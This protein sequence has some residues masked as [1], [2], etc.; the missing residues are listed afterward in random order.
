MK[1]PI[2]LAALL[3]ASVFA[4]ANAFVLARLP[5][6]LVDSNAVQ[7]QATSALTAANAFLLLKVPTSAPELG[8]TVTGTFS[9]TLVAQ[10]SDDGANWVTVNSYPQGSS[11]GQATVT[12]IG[13][14]RFG[15]GGHAQAR[16]FVS[17]YVSGSASVTMNATA[18][19]PTDIPTPVSG[20]VSQQYT[21]G[22]NASQ[23]LTTT[24]LRSCGTSSW[25]QTTATANA[26]LPR[27][28]FLTNCN[29]LGGIDAFARVY[30]NHTGD[31]T[32][33]LTTTDYQ[34][35]IQAGVNYPTV[36]DV[37]AGGDVFVISSGAG[38]VISAEERILK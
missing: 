19:E 18:M 16:V 12:G 24:I 10:V 14:Y 13:T 34:Y 17:A 35:K 7:V 38:A 29:A 33:T 21:Q 1:K 28:V 30:V 36:I 2:V 37:P 9:M 4:Q 23:A 32:V 22:F 20:I 27:R 15:A 25:T 11:T 3:C 5:N 6:L 8:F 31:N 26:A